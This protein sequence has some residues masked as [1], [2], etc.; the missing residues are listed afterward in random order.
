MKYSILLISANEYKLQVLKLVH[1]NN[2]GLK[3]A[4]QLVNSAPCIIKEDLSMSNA[5]E[6]NQYLKRVGAT[7]E[8]LDEKETKLFI[9]FDK[10]PSIKNC[11]FNYIK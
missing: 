3:E 7:S 1:N 4:L 9:E 2:I 5:V 11:L 6:I 8:I 10:R